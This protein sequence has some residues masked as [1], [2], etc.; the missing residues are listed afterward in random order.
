MGAINN[1]AGAAGA[2]GLVALG[3]AA[4]LGTVT[5]NASLRLGALAIGIAGLVGFK[6]RGQAIP[7]RAWIYGLLTI[8][9]AIA[10]A[11]LAVTLPV[12]VYRSALI[13]ILLAV[14]AQQLRNRT[15]DPN[16]E[17]TTTRWWPLLFLLIGLHMGFIQVAAG[18]LS[19][20]VLTALHRRDLVTTNATKM[21]IMICA[22]GTA[23]TYFAISGN[24]A[25][26]PAASL[27]LGCGAGSFWASRWSIDK[28]HAKVRLVVLAITVSVLLW[29]AWQILATS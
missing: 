23:V 5:A 7:P 27:A 14:L 26:G 17:V 2:L 15:P 20:L 13:T 19:I 11:W 6:S 9:G 25:W 10:G 21:A 3:M 8:P 28:G 12:W 29:A 1:M 4:G 22:A 24:I 18:L 16:T